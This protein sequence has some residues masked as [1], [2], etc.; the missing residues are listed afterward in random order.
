MHYLYHIRSHRSVN[1]H[2]VRTLLILHLVHC[3]RVGGGREGQRGVC[4]CVCVTL[5]VCLYCVYWLCVCVCVCAR[6]CM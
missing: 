6:V 4:A 2:K 5:C 1:D 3:Q